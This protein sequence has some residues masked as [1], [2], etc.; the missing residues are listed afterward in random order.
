LKQEICK[1]FDDFGFDGRDYYFEY[2]DDTT[3]KTWRLYSGKNGD[4]LDRFRGKRDDKNIWKV[5]KY[6]VVEILNKIFNG[7]DKNRSFK[8]QILD[9]TG[10]IGKA[11]DLKFAIDLIQQIR[12]F[13]EKDADGKP[14]KDDDFILSPVRDKDGSHFDSRTADESMPQNGDANGAYNIARK[15]LIAFKEIKANPEKPNL[16][17]SDKEWDVWLQDPQSAMLK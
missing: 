15:G 10:D 4:S 5:E 9:E 16:F 2:T 1:K 11:S 13:G 6:N 7:F 3:K 12:N 14:T 17:I 8:N